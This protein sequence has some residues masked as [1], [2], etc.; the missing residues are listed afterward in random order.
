MSLEDR[1][2]IAVMAKTPRAGRSKTR[3]CPPLL[4]EQA[5][6]LAGAFLS[7]VTGNIVRAGT[8]V[9]ADPWVA[10]APA[11]DECLFAGL[12]APTTRLLLA[13]GAGE[14]APGVEGFGRC[15]L[16]A[17][18][19][20]L[21]MGYGAACVLNA[22]SPTLPTAHLIS[23]ARQ[24][25]DG[26]AA[27]MGAAE[28]GGYYVLGMR[29]AHPRLFAGIAW[30]S[31]AVAEQTRARAHA[32]SLPLIELPA[33]YDVDDRAALARLYAEL[34]ADAVVAPATR[35]A[36]ARLGIADAA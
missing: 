32:M 18:R 34:A 26:A 10:Y 36:V 31:D 35:A 8:R 16:Q 33:W 14:D 21:D 12:L 13:D 9:P 30:S 22:D 2:A 15:L 11:G 29:A 17:I 4:P 25:R 7:D 28:D 24:L 27:V 23:L 5:A 6:E 20:L 1:V 3:L 19:R